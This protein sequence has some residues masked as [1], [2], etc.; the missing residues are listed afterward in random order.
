MHMHGAQVLEA[1]HLGCAQRAAGMQQGSG[2]SAAAEGDQQWQRGLQADAATLGC[3]G[4]VRLS[5]GGRLR[6]SLDGLTQCLQQAEFT[7][8]RVTRRRASFP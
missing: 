7:R 5:G 4:G 1:A 2:I 3:E 6:R 8:W